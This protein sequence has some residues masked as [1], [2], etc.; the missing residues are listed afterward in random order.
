ML[1]SGLSLFDWLE[2]SG[3]TAENYF[4]ATRSLVSSTPLAS[5]GRIASPQR[6]TSNGR[7]TRAA[8]TS[9]SCSGSWAPCSD[10]AG[11]ARP[12][13]R[14]GLSGDP[15][16]PELVLL[17]TSGDAHRATAWDLHAL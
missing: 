4:S 16:D 14:R 10:R 17:R 2:Y 3:I 11:S 7:W 8:P 12:A 13:A 15:C 1:C 5:P 6:R 9:T